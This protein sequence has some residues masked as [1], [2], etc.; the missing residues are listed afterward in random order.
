MLKSDL[1]KILKMTISLVTRNK[2]LAGFV[3][4]NAPD[5]LKC[6]LR[7]PSKKR[8]LK[9]INAFFQPRLDYFYVDKIF[10]FIFGSN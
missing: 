9:K 7:L 8:I 4:F 2:I 5:I 3:N 6:I 10:L 1:M